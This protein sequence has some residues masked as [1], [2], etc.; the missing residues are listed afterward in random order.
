MSAVRLFLGKA[1]SCWVSASCCCKGGGAQPPKGE[2]AQMREGQWPEGHTHRMLQPPKEAGRCLKKVW[3]TAESPQAGPWQKSFRPWDGQQRG[4]VSDGWARLPWT[5]VWTLS[6]SAPAVL[7]Q[8]AR[9][10]QCGVEAPWEG[11]LGDQWVQWP[12]T[13]NSICVRGP[14]S[15][16]PKAQSCPAPGC[17]LPS[18]SPT[19]GLWEWWSPSFLL[20]H[21]AGKL[22]GQ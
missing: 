12:S 8:G 22:Q 6:R 7:S 17:C 19:S 2:G 14:F 3:R 13:V 4:P 16:S 5:W 10:A 20:P 18:S 11:G 15:T 21:I 1:R 9:E